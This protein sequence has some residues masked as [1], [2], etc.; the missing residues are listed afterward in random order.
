[1]AGL[2][3]AAF[4]STCRMGG[5]SMAFTEVACATGLTH[6]SGRTLFL[7][8]SFDGERPTAA[9]LFGSDPAD[10]AEAARRAEALG[11]FDLI[12]I[13][14]GCPVRRVM[15]RGAGAALM[16][17]PERVRD[18]VRAVT[19]AV[20]LPVT[21]KTRLGP[22][23]GTVSALDIARAT[24]DGGGV[25]LFVHARYTTQVHQGP[26]DLATLASIVRS[27]PVPVVANG[28][29]GDAAS[30]LRV[31]SETGAAGLMIGRAAVGRP[32]MFGEIRAALT[33]EAPP[34]EPTDTCIRAVIRG[35]ID[36]EYELRLREVRFRYTRR[37]EPEA[38]AAVSFRA[39]LLRYLAGRRG[40]VEVR[41][42][43]NEVL[44]LEDV[45]RLA[46]MVLEPEPT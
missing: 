9:H 8:E 10:M 15:A 19:S 7:L 27:S 45:W 37:R 24:A 20:S 36:R 21:V 17:K 23:P 42:H 4:R 2:T 29:I 39:H 30:S 43:L 44:R 18:I 35:H 34:P 33:G 5:A 26:T 28:S 3:D 41:R 25:A 31:L 46:D 32:W 22:K 38:A 13:N 40:S 11:R 12:D 14:C 6:N 16:H 1:M